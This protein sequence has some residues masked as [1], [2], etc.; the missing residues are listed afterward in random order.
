MLIVNTASGQFLFFVLFTCCFRAGYRLL[1]PDDE[2]LALDM[3]SDAKDAKSSGKQVL[4]LPAVVLA[5]LTRRCAEKSRIYSPT[6]A[7]LVEDKV[8]AE[9]AAAQ[10]D[11]TPQVCLRVCCF[12]LFQFG[13]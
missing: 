1:F 10:K 13:F 2:K 7:A 9:V 6:L 12:V 4:S 8:R 11:P 5:A 3:P